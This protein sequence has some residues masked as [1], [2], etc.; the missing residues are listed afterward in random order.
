MDKW[1]R[2]LKAHGNKIERAELDK[3]KKYEEKE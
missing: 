2:K 1:E 3:K